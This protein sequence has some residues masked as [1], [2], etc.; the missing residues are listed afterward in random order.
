MSADLQFCGPEEI[1]TPD[2][3]RA[4]R[5][6]PIYGDLQRRTFMTIYAGHGAIFWLRVFTSISAYIRR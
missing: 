4:R 6:K 5:V 3:T 1:R 2:L